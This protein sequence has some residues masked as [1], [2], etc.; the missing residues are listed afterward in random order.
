[1]MNPYSGAMDFTG[2]ERIQV[3]E[4]KLLHALAEVR[5]HVAANLYAHGGGPDWFETLGSNMCTLLGVDMTA[6]VPS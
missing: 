2:L 5:D 4:L 1:M 6:H 3:A